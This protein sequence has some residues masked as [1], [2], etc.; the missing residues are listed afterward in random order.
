MSEYKGGGGLNYVHVCPT[1]SM[2][3]Y[4]CMH[5]LMLSQIC[6]LKAH[7]HNVI[8]YMHAHIH[9]LTFH[10]ICTSKAHRSSTQWPCYET[11][12]HKMRF[13]HFEV[14]TL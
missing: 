9:S 12:T 7:L 2:I 11:H 3:T 13:L 5:G 4:A 14:L 10:K 1:V 6:T 8:T